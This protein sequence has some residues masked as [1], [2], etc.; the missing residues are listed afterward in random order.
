MFGQCSPKLVSKIQGLGMYVQANIDQDIV[1]LLTII[2][3]YCCLFGNHQQSTFALKGVKHCISTYY[4]G[5]KVSTTE[6][7]EHFKALVGVL[8][9]YGGAYGNKPGLIT[10]QLIAQG[11]PDSVDPDQI[12]KAEATLLR[13]FPLM[14]DHERIQPNHYYQLKNDLANN[15]TKGLDHFPKTIVKTMHLLN[16]YKVSA[17][18]QC[19]RE[20]DGKSIASC[21]ATNQQRQRP[22]QRATLSAGIATRRGITR[23]SAQ[24]FKCWM[25]GCRICTPMTGRSTWT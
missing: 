20:P 19:H 3:G 14:Y 17:R 13:A 2:R 22:C 15:M 25:S 8:E 11:A 1:Q 23:K 24:N 4:Q 21:K 12:A 7:V 16:D 9:T 5:Y 6:Y 18:H 10:A